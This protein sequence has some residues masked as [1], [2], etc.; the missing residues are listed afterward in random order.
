MNEL[1]MA[2]ILMLFVISWLVEHIGSWSLCLDIHFKVKEYNGMTCQMVTSIVDWFII[3][4]AA[5]SCLKCQ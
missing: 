3:E 4:M 5:I 2:A 1:K